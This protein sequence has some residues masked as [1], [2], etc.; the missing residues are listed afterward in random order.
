VQIY[1][2][3]TYIYSFSRTNKKLLVPKEIERIQSFIK[4]IIAYCDA[5]NTENWQ[6]NLIADELKM[7]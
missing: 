1:I 5:I 3:N 6:Q 7:I 4:P 2:I